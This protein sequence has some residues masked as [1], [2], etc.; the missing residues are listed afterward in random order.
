MAF[1]LRPGRA[2]LI[3]LIA[4]AVITSCDRK[5]STNPPTEIV[6]MEGV[7]IKDVCRIGNT[8]TGAKNRLKCA[9]PSSTAGGPASGSEAEYASRALPVTL[10]TMGSGNA[11]RIARV[12]I[13]L[14]PVPSSTLPGIRTGMGLVLNSAT[15]RRSITNVYGQAG[16]KY[17]TL[18]CPEVWA[19][20]RDGRAY[21]VA[22]P[23]RAQF[24]YLHYPE[25]GISF[26]LESNVVRKCSVEEPRKRVIW[27]F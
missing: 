13:V 11:E 4:I 26:L 7:G 21:S 5:P 16:A 23:E 12:S 3:F 15:S 10:D 2:A 14:P 24:E 19:S 1:R 25:P 20:I 27:R 8:P 22:P 9:G 17:A 6:L 18:N